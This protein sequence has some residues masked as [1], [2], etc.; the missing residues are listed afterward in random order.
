MRT[1]SA[2]SVGGRVD[3]MRRADG[4]AVVFCTGCGSF[5][6]RSEQDELILLVP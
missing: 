1:I 3:S 2:P 6:L 4:N 5:D